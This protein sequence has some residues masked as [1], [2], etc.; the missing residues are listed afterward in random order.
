MT[1]LNTR[2]RIAAAFPATSTETQ[3]YVVPANTEIDGLLRI[4]NQNAA[5][6]TFRIG[7]CQAGHGDTNITNLG[8]WIF[9]DT[10]IGANT[11]QELSV[12][13]QATETLRIKVA[14][15]NTISFHLS[16]NVKV[17]S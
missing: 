14:T 7:H 3:L 13:M 4:C 6:Q 15:G 8:N 10:Q 2:G 16:G 12:H 11:T 1:V 5:T 17:T 9:Y